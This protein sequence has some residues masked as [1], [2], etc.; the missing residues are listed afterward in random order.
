MWSTNSWKLEEVERV[1]ACGMIRVICLPFSMSLKYTLTFT[2][3]FTE[4]KHGSW[5]RLGVRLG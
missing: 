4:T 3:L 5:E 1:V 2:I